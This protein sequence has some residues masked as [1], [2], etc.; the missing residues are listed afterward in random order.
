MCGLAGG[1]PKDSKKGFGSKVI[2]DLI[3]LTQMRGTD[4]LGLL[5]LT[6]KPNK[7]R[8][9]EWHKEQGVPSWLCKQSAFTT[10]L[11]QNNTFLA[12][13]CR[14]ATRG[15]VSK[16]NAHPFRHGDIVL[17]HN[18]TLNTSY[19][20]NDKYFEV[21]S[22][23]IT[24][25]LSDKKN[26][27]QELVT[28][29]DG[30]YA[31]VW[32]DMSNNTL[33][34]LRNNDRPLWFVDTDV[35][36]LWASERCMLEFIV[37]RHDLSVLGD[38]TYTELEA[39]TH[40]VYNLDTAKWSKFQMEEPP[41]KV[42]QTHSY[43]G[44]FYS[45]YYSENEKKGSSTQV[46]GNVKHGD[47]N[48]STAATE[49]QSNP[50]KA[51]QMHIAA[52]TR[53][54]LHSISPGLITRDCSLPSIQTCINSGWDFVINHP[55]VSD[56]MFNPCIAVHE[57]L[58][59]SIANCRIIN[60]EHKSGLLTVSVDLPVDVGMDDIADFNFH[61]VMSAYTYRRAKR[62]GLLVEGTISDFINN[63]ENNP[64]TVVIRN[65]T[66]MLCFDPVITGQATLEEVMEMM[67][68]EAQTC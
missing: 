44:N 8:M 25:F 54:P 24:F 18:G 41:V 31:L 39:F 45:E 53:Y 9:F 60:A 30:A 35:G 12:F 38:A 50:C 4:S 63:G 23:A 68:G 29:A 46:N 36:I 58:Y 67:M 42:F 56:A 22:E 6:V 3:Y 2:N 19:Q 32:A 40:V 5:T 33:N 55:N 59:F 49:W 10:Q 1:I 21:D 16:D 26:S 28:A 61:A 14:A 7:E 64:E 27:V 43:Y 66:D 47:T 17:M 11:A 62:Y 34:F 13:H 15:K 48:K 65:C 51:L 20:L 52:D 57:K 37:S